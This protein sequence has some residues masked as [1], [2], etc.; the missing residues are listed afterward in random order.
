MA[1]TRPS[2]N[3]DPSSPPC[4]QTLCCCSDLWVCGPSLVAGQHTHRIQWSFPMCLCQQPHSPAIT[5]MMSQVSKLHGVCDHMECRF[6]LWHCLGMLGEGS[7]CPVDTVGSHSFMVA[8]DFQLD[9]CSLVD[10][11]KSELEKW[12]VSKELQ[13]APRCLLLVLKGNLFYHHA[14]CFRISKKNLGAFQGNLP[15][16]PQSAK[17]CLNVL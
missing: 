5:V 15:L 2:P 13:F 1:I 6:L 12:L 10:S 14:E 9:S 3:F 8:L 4:P 11:K 17:K 16:A 7:L